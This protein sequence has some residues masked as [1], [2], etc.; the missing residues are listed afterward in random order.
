MSKNVFHC[1]IVCVHVSI[2]YVRVFH[3]T[4]A[5][6]TLFSNIGHYDACVMQ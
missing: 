6:L 2:M 3:V 1:V 5:Y 4:A